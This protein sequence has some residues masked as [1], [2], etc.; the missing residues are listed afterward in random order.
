MALCASTTGLLFLVSTVLSYI[1]IHFTTR[2]KLPESIP[3]TGLKSG[4]FK[5]QRAHLQELFRGRDYLAEGCSKYSKQGKPFATPNFNFVPDIIVPPAYASWIDKQPENVLS[6][7][8]GQLYFLSKYT[9][10]HERLHRD[11]LEDNLARTQQIMRLPTL[12]TEVMDELVAALNDS[13]GSNTTE[14]TAV[15]P[16][17]TMFYVVSRAAHRAF[18][19]RELCRDEG[20]LEAVKAYVNSFA[21][22]GILIRFFI[23]ELLKPLFG[24]LLAIPVHRRYR[25]LLDGYLVPLAEKLIRQEDRGEESLAKWLRVAAQSHSDPEERTAEA[26]TGQLASAEFAPLHTSTYSIT[27]TLLDLL[28]APQAESH[29]ETLREEAKSL[30]GDSS[31]WTRAQV[32]RLELADSVI[33][34]SLR[35]TRTSGKAMLRRVVAKKGVSLPDGTRLPY[36][37]YVGLSA[38]SHMDGDYYDDPKEFRPWR[39]VPDAQKPFAAPKRMATTSTEFLSFGHGRHS[40]PGRFFVAQFLTALLACIARDYDTQPLLERP[41]GH[42][43]SDLSTPPTDGRILIRRRRD[44]SL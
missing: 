13:W 5:E 9:F 3:W 43:V 7:R 1:L 33:R 39:F 26:L 40:C 11:T 44:Q 34:E 35:V 16:F 4:V 31:Q 23:P 42:S 41:M 30:Q 15:N 8:E 17:E 37:V 24:R 38:E 32:L 25:Q 22:Q 19:G 20:F 21:T 36:G 18:V 29:L 6:A 14:W 10:S 27:S 2:V 28:S 12:H